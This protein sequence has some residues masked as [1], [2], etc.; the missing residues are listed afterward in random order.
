MN[1]LLL[2]SSTKR[3][4]VALLNDQE[5]DFITQSTVIIFRLMLGFQLDFLVK[6]YMTQILMMV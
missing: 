3:F 6:I 5:N 1:I 4:K 2:N